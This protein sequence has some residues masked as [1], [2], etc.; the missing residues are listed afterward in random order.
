MNHLPLLLAILVV[1]V[2]GIALWILVPGEDPQE[3]AR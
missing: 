2:A 1:I 3:T